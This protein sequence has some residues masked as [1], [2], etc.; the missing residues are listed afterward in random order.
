[1]GENCSVTKAQHCTFSEIK[2][3]VAKTNERLAFQKSARKA[4]VGQSELFYPQNTE[5]TFKSWVVY[6][7]DQ[8]SF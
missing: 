3:N 6:F 5:R 7:W 8:K 4:G 1:M 2:Y